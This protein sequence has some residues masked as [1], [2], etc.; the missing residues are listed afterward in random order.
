MSRD[1]GSLFGLRISAVPSAL[2]GGAAVWL[3]WTLLAMVVFQ[4]DVFAAL[5][6]GALALAGYWLSDL[7]HQLGHAWAARRTGY[8]MVGIR[9]WGPFSASIYPPD[10]PV[11]PAAVHIRRALGG[12][13]ISLVM[14]APTALLALAAADAAPL[15]R[16]L[17]LFL[18]LVNV[19][20][21]V[22]VFLPLGFNDGSTLLYWLRRGR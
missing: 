5:S 16:W 12:P 10:E 9:F 2:A 7:I 19:G 15:W 8:P 13:L 17:T 22:Q 1:L 11:L 20:I 3:I 14:C 4:V 21:T 6:G 18:F